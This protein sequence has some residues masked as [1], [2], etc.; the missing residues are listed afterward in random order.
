MND[1]EKN[2]ILES[3]EVLQKAEIH[4]CNLQYKYR[5]YTI[6][7]VMGIFGAIGFLMSKKTSALPVNE[8]FLISCITIAGS[9]AIA[10]IWSIDILLY[11]KLLDTVFIQELE[12]ERKY[13]FLPQVRH[14]ML[15]LSQDISSIKIQST[16]YIGIISMCLLSSFFTIFYSEINSEK[17]YFLLTMLIPLI[18]II[19]I[20]RA[21]HK[22][23]GDINQ[24][25][26]YLN[27]NKNE[28]LDF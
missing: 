19:I 12:M 10:L 7:W 22:Q 13:S 21:M 1:E 2:F 28:T 16:F 27:E 26:H 11:Q 23:S 15:F 17:W 8:F 9:V 25:M 3:Y 6:Y 14:K 24:H 18:L 4:F 20:I 5:E